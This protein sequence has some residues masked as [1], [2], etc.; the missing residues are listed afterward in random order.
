[1]TGGV[2]FDNTYSGITFVTSG[3]LLLGKTPGVIAIPG[4]LVIGTG[5]GPAENAVVTL[6]AN[7]QFSP[8][9]TNITINADGCLNLNGFTTQFAS[10]NLNGG[11]L[12]TGSGNNITINGPV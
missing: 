1:M 12:D 7:G 3:D 2:T 8:D 10:L 11:C 4:D 9:A 5:T 6:E